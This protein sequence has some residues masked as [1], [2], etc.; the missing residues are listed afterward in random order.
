MEKGIEIIKKITS[1]I[2]KQLNINFKISSEAEIQLSSLLKNKTYRQKEIIIKQGEFCNKLYFVE[3]GLIRQFYFKKNRDITED[4]ADEGKIFSVA[5]S[6]LKNEPSLLNIET[7]EKTSVYYFEYQDLD[8]LASINPEVQ[9]FY[10]CMNSVAILV[11]NFKITSLRY[12][13]AKER[14]EKFIKFF[15][16]VAKKAPLQYIA[17]YLHMTKESLSRVRA[18]KL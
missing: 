8:H 1:D 12:E 2:S 10:R 5:E 11:S 13:T 9:Y 18:G 16:N 17:S 3:T 7:L 6:Y 15:P 14:Y 4:F